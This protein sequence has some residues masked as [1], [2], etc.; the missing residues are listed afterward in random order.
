M[1]DF[2][3]QRDMLE[4]LSSGNKIYVRHY[5]DQIRSMDENAL[6]IDANTGE[7][8]SNIAF[9]NYKNFGKVIP[10]RMVKVYRPKWF[11]WCGKYFD[12]DFAGWAVSQDEW[13]RG[14]FCSKISDEWEEKE[15][16]A[17][18]FE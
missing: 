7:K 13:K 8:F 2:K 4:W 6:L 16:P 5:P 18:V 15:V 1:A 10:Q 3:N 17:E 12:S 14:I 9:F 11:I